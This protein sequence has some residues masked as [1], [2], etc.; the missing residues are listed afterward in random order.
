MKLLLLI[1]H[2]RCNKIHDQSVTLYALG[3]IVRG[4][5][6][7]IDGRRHRCRNVLPIFI[8]EYGICN[9]FLPQFLRHIFVHLSVKLCICRR[10][11]DQ[12]VIQHIRI[13]AVA[14]IRIIAERTNK[15]CDE[16][17]LVFFADSS[18]VC[19][20]M[21]RRTDHNKIGIVNVHVCFPRKKVYT[22]EI[23]VY[24]HGSLSMTG[25]VLV[26][27]FWNEEYFSQSV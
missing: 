21:S 15:K 5:I 18:L 13:S 14:N 4:D 20:F 19:H 25:F 11:L 24:V 8:K 26:Y 10:K 23:C 17:R 16:I 1:Q 6:C 12:H 9:I 27:I 3:L 7:V 2:I 22:P